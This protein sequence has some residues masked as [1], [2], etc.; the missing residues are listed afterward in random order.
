MAKLT[1]RG[2]TP[3]NRDGTQT[4]ECAAFVNGE[5]YRNG[6]KSYGDAYDIN[7]QFNEIFNG[8]DASGFDRDNVNLGKTRND[9]IQAI[10]GV[11]NRASDAVR[12]QFDSRT[13]DKNH[14]YTVNMYYT[15]SPHMVD[16]YN[17]GTD[18]PGTH[19]GVLY[20]S[21]EVG[22]WRVHHNIHGKIYDDDFISLQGGNKPYGVTAIS[23]ANDT[24]LSTKLNP[25]RWFRKKEGGKL[26]K[27]RR[28]V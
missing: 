9:S 15:N 19:T 8:Y 28:F 26:I 20:W 25:F 16:Y 6:I 18:T 12:K 11:H 27:K 23:D 22:R 3:T 24:K 13:L 14:L 4:N 21:P 2:Q 17:K 10:R 1:K 5:L 7:G